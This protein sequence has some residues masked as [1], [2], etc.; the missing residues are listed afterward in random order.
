[1]G[2][3]LDDATD[4]GDWP[5]NEDCHD[6]ALR[7]PASVEQDCLGG[8]DLPKTLRPQHSSLEDPRNLSTH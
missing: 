1:M 8:R 4:I 5:L 6:I 7:L 2:K 3:V